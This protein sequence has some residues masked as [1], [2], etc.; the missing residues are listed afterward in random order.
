MWGIL[1]VT[2]TMNGDQT[3]GTDIYMFGR[4]FVEASFGG[5]ALSF[6]PWPPK[7]KQARVYSLKRI[8][9]Q[10]VTSWDDALHDF[11]DPDRCLQAWL[12]GKSTHFD[13]FLEILLPFQYD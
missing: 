2:L 3:G 4:F 1:G 13:P 5:Q 11:N 7:K 8:E 10:S 12:A 9:R 6:F